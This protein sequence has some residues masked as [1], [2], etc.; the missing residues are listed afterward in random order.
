MVKK[1]A[2]LEIGQTNIETAKC[3]DGKRSQRAGERETGN[4]GSANEKCSKIRVVNVSWH[5]TNAQVINV[6]LQF[7]LIISKMR[8]KNRRRMSR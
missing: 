2:A 5:S 1:S 6:Y 8:K 4:D 7:N 3:F